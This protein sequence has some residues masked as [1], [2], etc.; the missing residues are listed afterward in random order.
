MADDVIRKVAAKGGVICINF[1]AGSLNAAAH[2]VYIKNRPKR[3]AEIKAAG[4]DWELVRRIQKRYYDYMPRVGVKELL[5]HID[6][7]ARLVGPDHVGFGSDFDGISGMVPVG[8]EDVS[9]YPVLVNGLIER[10]Y[11]DEDIGKGMG[12]N[13][14]GG[15]RG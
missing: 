6:Y 1:H 12:G 2:E 3:D 11:K 14:V 10:G 4:S 7:V 13:L 15:M 5:R 8:M 9:K